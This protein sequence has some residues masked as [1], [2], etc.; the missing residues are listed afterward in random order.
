MR[1]GN[2]FP[3]RT[4]PLV[5]CLPIPHL[6]P[7]PPPRLPAPEGAPDALSA[8]RCSFRAPQFRHMNA[9]VIYQ[10]KFTSLNQSSRNLA[11]SPLQ[12]RDTFPHVPVPRPP[13]PRNWPCAPLRVPGLPRLLP[14]RHRRLFKRRRQEAGSRG[15]SRRRAGG[16]PPPR[17]PRAGGCGRPGARACPRRGTGS[18]RRAPPAP[19]A[20]PR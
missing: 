9:R 17:V 4:S 10:G 7:P 6:P 1:D 11:L 8:S 3:T 14:S 18:A 15:A 16:H 12:S 13:S 2:H 20:A 19:A 5:A